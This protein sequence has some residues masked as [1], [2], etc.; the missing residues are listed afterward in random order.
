MLSASGKYNTVKANSPNRDSIP[1]ETHTIRLK[2][3]DPVSVKTPFGEMNIPDP[4]KGIYQ[5]FI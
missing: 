3:T 2:P 4:E 5:V 1:L